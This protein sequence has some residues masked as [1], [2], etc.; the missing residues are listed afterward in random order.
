MRKKI[1]LYFFNIYKNIEIKVLKKTQLE[2]FGIIEMLLL[3]AI[4]VA[5]II[6]FK[7]E[8]ETIVN[9]AIDSIKGKAGKIVS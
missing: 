8:I 1:K 6:L 5:L 9:N 3:L 7:G 4:V 2:G